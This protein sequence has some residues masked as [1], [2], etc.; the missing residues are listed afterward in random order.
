M[1]LFTFHTAV[2][3]FINS[4]LDDFK[5][6]QNSVVMGKLSA[7]PMHASLNS[8]KPLFFQEIRVVSCG[9]EFH[10]KCVDPWLLTNYTC[11]L[12]MLNIVGK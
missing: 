2:S 3:W 7:D 11:P 5:R 9:H 4:V 12:C 8:V 6:F 10:L 1:A